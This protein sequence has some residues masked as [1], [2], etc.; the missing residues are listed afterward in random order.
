MNSDCCRRSGRWE[1]TF[2]VALVALSLF[3]STAWD[4]TVAIRNL[5]DESHFF[6]VVISLGL[7]IVSAACTFAS[8]ALSRP[9]LRYTLL[10]LVGV[11]SISVLFYLDWP[12]ALY[13][14]YFDA[15]N[16]FGCYVAIGLIPSVLAA[17]IPIR[18]RKG[19]H[20]V[21]PYLAL[22]AMALYVLIRP[23]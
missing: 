15:A 3:A 23:S 12:V 20:L 21:V 16:L 10:V 7:A 17:L 6:D 18:K 9:H 11:I 2:G 22:A 4:G 1:L 5:N 8:L 14:V 13:Y 19:W